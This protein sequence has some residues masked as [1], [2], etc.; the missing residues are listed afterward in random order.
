MGISHETHWLEPATSDP[1][2]IKSKRTPGM[3]HKKDFPRAPKCGFH[4]HQLPSG[5]VNSLRSGMAH[6]IWSL[7][8]IACISIE[9]HGTSACWGQRFWSKNDPQVPKGFGA[10]DVHEWYERDCP[11]PSLPDPAPESLTTSVLFCEKILWRNSVIGAV[12]DPSAKKW[13][14]LEVPKWL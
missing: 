14:T 1:S 10:A 7:S 2:G 9:Q 12:Q 3:A 13:R 5:H 4:K 6:K 8:G 11:T